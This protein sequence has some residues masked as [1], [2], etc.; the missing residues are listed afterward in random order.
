MSDAELASTGQALLV[1]G[2]ETTANMIGKMTAM[3]LADRQRW[4]QL[5]A[6]PSLVRTAVEEALRFDANP[7]IGIPRYIDEEVEV[8]EAVLAPGTTVSY[9]PSSGNGEKLWSCQRRREVSSG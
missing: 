9:A 8:G 6:D 4:A 2:H 5:V 3:L 1:A 7:G